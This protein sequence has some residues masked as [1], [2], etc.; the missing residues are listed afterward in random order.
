ML[1]D[2]H[3]W[4]QVPLLIFPMNLQPLNWMIVVGKQCAI[5]ERTGKTCSVNAFSPSAGTMHEVP[6][7][8]AA[9]AYDFPLIGK[10]YIFLVRNALYIPEISHN[11]LPPL[12]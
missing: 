4:L 6:I 7:V 12:Y 11:L 2:L 5:F 1:H 9:L 8:D 10:T 3:L